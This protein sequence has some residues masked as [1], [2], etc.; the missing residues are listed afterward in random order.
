[1]GAA[2]T[3]PSS[4]MQPLIQPLY[5]GHSAHEILASFTNEADKTGYEIVRDYWK[6][7]R[8]E[9][10]KAYEA[11]WETSL[12]DGVMAGTALAA[13]CGDAR[14]LARWRRP[15]AR[16]AATI[17]KSYSDPIRR[18]SMAGSRI[19]AGCRNCPSRTPS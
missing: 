1:M 15:R 4:V 16:G 10:D 19:T 5:D 3:A 11:F 7:Q 13:D 12:H 17:S 8:P 14:T 18:F 2:T 9:K 6:S